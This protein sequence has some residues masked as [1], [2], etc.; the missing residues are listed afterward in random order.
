[1]QRFTV[2]RGLQYAEVYSGQRFTVWRGLQCEEDYSVQRFTVQHTL[3]RR[4][5]AGLSNIF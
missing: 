3:D 1:M 5:F 2:C 4:L